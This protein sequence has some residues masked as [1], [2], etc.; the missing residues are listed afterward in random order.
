[1]LESVN[2]Q[3]LL[4]TT[5]LC[6]RVVRV[7][8]IKGSMDQLGMNYEILIYSPPSGG[9]EMASGWLIGFFFSSECPQESVTILFLSCSHIESLK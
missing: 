5:Y 8:W 1:M 3:C 6:K 4:K 2:A 7:L 9:F